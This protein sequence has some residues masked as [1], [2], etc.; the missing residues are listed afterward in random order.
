MVDVSKIQ[1]YDVLVAQAQDISVKL[2]S[3]RSL[4]DDIINFTESSKELLVAVTASILD[5]KVNY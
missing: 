2:T 1:G 5:F 3:F 4:V